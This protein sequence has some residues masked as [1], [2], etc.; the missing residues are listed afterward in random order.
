[1]QKIRSFAYAPTDYG[2]HRTE[3]VPHDINIYQKRH[4]IENM[5]GRVK[6]WRKVANHY[7]RSAALESGLMNGQ[8][9]NVC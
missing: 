4:K 5:F 9:V 7:D 1:M 8:S 6:D 2:P 3:T